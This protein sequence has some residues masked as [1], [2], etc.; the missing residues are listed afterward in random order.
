MKRTCHECLGKRS[1][2]GAYERNELALARGFTLIE[3]CATLCVLIILS[4]L[5]AV[6]MTSTLVNN[7]AYA[8]QD[9][10]VANVAYARSEAMRRG[11]NV[12]IGATAAASGNAFGGGWR[13][14][15]DADGDGAYD[16]GD[17]LL[18]THEAVPS[19]VVGDGTVQTIGFTPMGFLTPSA[20]VDIKVCPTD[21]TLGGFD[22]A[23]QP[24]GLTDVTDVSA[25]V[26]P[27]T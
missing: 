5:A 14:W 12:V 15:V 20:A 3:L 11:V 21:H 4:A 7:R 22:I 9:E 25:N 6:S 27:C 1:I 10:F 17:T 8:T 16:A 26:A 2:A 13:V 19:I 18:R 24:S 23:I